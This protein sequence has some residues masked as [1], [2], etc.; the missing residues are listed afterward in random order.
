MNVKITSYNSSM[1][2]LVFPNVKKN[3]DAQ[4]C[5][6]I[7]LNFFFFYWFKFILFKFENK[8]EY[9]GSKDTCQGKIKKDNFHENV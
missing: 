1:C 8:G 7:I 3:W 2:S 4:I 6:G 5:A 9:S